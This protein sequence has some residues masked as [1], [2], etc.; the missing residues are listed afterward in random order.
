MRVVVEAE[1]GHDCSKLLGGPGKRVGLCANRVDLGAHLLDQLL[2]LNPQPVQSVYARL[3]YDWPDAEVESH[4]VVTMTFEGG[5]TAI[6]D[7]G[8]MTRF[9]KPR[10][11]AV[12]T[13]ATFV[14]YGED[15]QERAMIAGDI[16]ASAEDPAR[17]A[18]LY[19]GKQERILNPQPGRW[20]SFYEN[21]A[22]ALHGRA[23][24]AVKLDEMRRLMAVMDAISDSARTGQ[25]VC[26]Q[27]A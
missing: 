26:P 14:K 4:A 11:Y 19:D 20:R 5:A 27:V 13:D 9:P 23:E 18:R 1:L 15:P 8:S 24:P 16:D 21:V 3:H 7:V 12:G 17:F 10:M 22:D 25:A 2:M 6:M